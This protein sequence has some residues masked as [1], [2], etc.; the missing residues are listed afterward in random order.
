M[1][2]EEINPII[3]AVYTVGNSFLGKEPEIGDL[4][5]REKVQYDVDGVIISIAITG[6]FNGKCFLS[7]NNKSIKIIAGSMIGMEVKEI[8]DMVKSAVSEFCNMIM[9]NA[10]TNFSV[11]DRSVNIG[12]PMALESGIDITNNIKFLGLPFWINKD[13][14]FELYLYTEEK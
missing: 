14:N 8:D 7:F 1:R 4:F 2:V 6:D 13:Y 11:N 5:V 3:E 12:S 10:A 9:G